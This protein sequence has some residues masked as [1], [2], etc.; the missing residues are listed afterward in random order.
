MPS[1]SSFF[2]YHYLPLLPFIHHHISASALP[3][4]P[5]PTKGRRRHILRVMGRGCGGSAGAVGRQL[6]RLSLEL[7]DSQVRRG[8]HAHAL[9]SGGEMSGVDSDALAIGLL[10]CERRKGA[11]EICDVQMGYSA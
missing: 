11:E 3:F 1:Y 8:K 5:L 9:H 4:L 2:R 10:W 7:G 6:Q